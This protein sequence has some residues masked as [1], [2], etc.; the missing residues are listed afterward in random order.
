MT[1][2]RNA[3]QRMKAEFRAF[4]ERA[5]LGGDR[6]GKTEIGDDA[7]IACRDGWCVAIGI[8]EGQRLPAGN[9]LDTLRRLAN[10]SPCVVA[11][12]ARD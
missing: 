1:I 9:G 5:G 4:D 12:Q 7:M 11:A 10:F 8:G 6:E 3:R 2:Q